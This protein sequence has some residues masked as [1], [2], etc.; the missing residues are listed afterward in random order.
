[1]RRPLLRYFPKTCTDVLRYLFKRILLFVPTLFAVSLLTF[2][3]SKLAPGDPVELLLRA[4]SG[5]MEG[6]VLDAERVYRETAA[7]LGLD[8]PPFYV[9]L[10]ARA[11]PDTLYRVANR[12]QRQVLRQLIAQHGNWP[13]I[14]HYFLQLREL[15]V[16]LQHLPDSLAPEA[17]SVLRRTADLLVRR[18]RDPAIRSLLDELSEEAARD[19]QLRRRLAPSIEALR[20]AYRTVISHPRRDLLYLLDI[21]YHGLDNQYDRWFIGLWR[22]DFGVSYI[23]SRPVG[24]KLWEALRWTLLLNGLAITLAYLLSIPLGVYSA[25]RRGSRFDRWTTVG[26]FMLYSLPTFWIAT[27]LVVFFTTP[28]YGMDLFPT[29]GIGETSKEVPFWERFRDRAYHLVLPVFCLTYGS[30]AFITRQMRGGMQEAL[31]RDYVRTAR[32]KGLSAGQV[33][34][35][36]AFRNALFPIITLLA[37]VLPAVLAGSVVIEVIFNIHGMGKL[38]VDAITQRDW[39]VVYGVLILSAVLTMIGIL[40]ADVLYKLADPRVDYRR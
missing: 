39:P 32:A 35:K 2:G 1:M 37:S 18:H 34:W 10:T 27:L 22:G 3:L 40:L 16:A 17:A 5:P 21:K 9:A 13:A 30:L 14:E 25:V 38:T 6:D 8:K 11:Y 24:A 15:T 7:F 29:M 26:L 36:H 12:D 28:E 33:T 23:D 20:A 19:P 4:G 31:G